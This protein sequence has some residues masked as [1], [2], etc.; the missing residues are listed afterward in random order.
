MAASPDLHPVP[1][2]QRYFV[3][4]TSG[5]QKWT[6]FAAAG[7]LVMAGVLIATG[8]RRAGLTVAAA[9]A[10]FAVAEEHEAIETLWK[11]LPGYLNEAQTML[12]KVEGYMNEAIAQGHKLKKIIRR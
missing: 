1:S 6:H 11:N 7:S 9:G 2:S 5:P 8:R 12:E 10:A 3:S 4:A